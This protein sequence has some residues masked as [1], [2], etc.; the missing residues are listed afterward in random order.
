M[1]KIHSQRVPKEES[2]P[3]LRRKAIQEEKMASAKSLDSREPWQA[4]GV[5]HSPGVQVFL[6]AEVWP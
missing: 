5:E 1:I 2:R 3:A 4:P 6:K